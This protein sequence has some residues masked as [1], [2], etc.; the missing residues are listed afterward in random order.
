MEYRGANAEPLTRLFTGTQSLEIIAIITV[1]YNLQSFCDR[2][3]NTVV[4]A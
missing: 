1:L 2:A 3:F 4:S